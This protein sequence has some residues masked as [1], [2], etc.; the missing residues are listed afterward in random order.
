MN[1]AHTRMPSQLVMKQAPVKERTPSFFVRAKYDFHSHKSNLLRFRAGAVIEV[2][3]Q[4][5]I[6]WW[7]G[8][9][10]ESTRGWFPSTYVD[11]ISD[12][13]ALRITGSCARARSP[14]LSQSSGTTD[15]SR[16]STSEPTLC[17]QAIQLVD[18][19]IQDINELISL[20]RKPLQEPWTSTSMDP[21]VQKLEAG[22]LKLGQSMR[23]TFLAIIQASQTDPESSYLC[24]MGASEA[25]LAILP[26]DLANKFPTLAVRVHMLIKYL[27]GS[28]HSSKNHTEYMKEQSCFENLAH[29]FIDTMTFLKHEVLDNQRILLSS[30]SESPLSMEDLGSESVQAADCSVSPA[31]SSSAPRNDSAKRPGMRR[32]ST[33]EIFSTLLRFSPVSIN[34]GKI[35]L[36]G[37]TSMSSDHR[38]PIV[39]PESPVSDTFLGSDIPPGDI[40]FS[41]QGTVKG[42]TLEALVVQLTRHDTFDTKYTMAFLTTF[43]SFT[44][45]ERLMEL[46][47]ERFHLHMPVGLDEGRLKQWEELKKIPVQLRTVNVMRLWLEYHC[48]GLKDEKALDLIEAF[49]NHALILRHVKGMRGMLLRLVDRRRQGLETIPKRFSRPKSMPQP[50]LP[51][52]MVKPSLLGI[53]PIELARQLTL[54]ESDLFFRIRPLECMNKA[55]TGPDA[56]QNARGIVDVISFHNRITDWV[57]NVVLMGE[58][59]EQRAI[60][61]SHFIAIAQ[62]CRL[63]NNFSTMWAI[64]SALNCA[65]IFRLNA[66]WSLLNNKSMGILAELNQITQASRNYHYYR[67]LLY[68]ISPPCVP[69]F[70]LYTKDL[71]FIED[72]N[73]DQ[74]YSDTRLIN[75]CKRFLITDVIVEIRRFQSTP[76]SLAR[77]PALIDF[78]EKQMQSGWDDDERYDRSLLLEPR[79]SSTQS[80]PPVRQNLNVLDT[81]ADEHL[82]NLLRQNGFI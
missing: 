69:F 81:E 30:R 64:F 38:V 40:V 31:L 8:L 78:L 58:T 14:Q 51:E 35:E 34:D 39:E 22:M 27:Q 48:V 26:K 17:A 76:Y 32:A 80:K 50:L 59:A 53:D 36:A 45:S 20:S 21:M 12:E 68:R 13:E 57:S 43:T 71:T 1:H 72:G 25:S 18:E 52:D 10:N 23:Q 19:F 56:F 60:L 9:L 61:M 42:G 5:D 4:L 55:W 15:S 44:T 66:S 46:L 49:A 74:M 41:P 82:S 65:S 67:E 16:S 77:V 11:T 3:G 2:L 7:D 54:M 70:G 29:Q 6:G 28:T 63:L 75:F 79:W 73:P 62:E 33:S 37:F 47:I 24:D